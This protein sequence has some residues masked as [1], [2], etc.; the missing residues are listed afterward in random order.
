MIRA[1]AKTLARGLS[2]VGLLLALSSPAAA[3]APAGLYTS[4]GNDA[5][6]GTYR[7]RVELRATGP[8]AYDY[9]R[10]A[11]FATQ[12]NG[13]SLTV[14]W[15][16][17]A[18]TRGGEVHV[19]V[20]LRRVGWITR[21]GALQRTAA[22]AV[23]TSVTGVYRPDPAGGLAGVLRDATGAVS[24]T[25][26]ITYQGAP[27]AS[28]L[29]RED[30]TLG[31][32]HGPPPGWLKSVL[33]AVFNSF[34]VLPDIQPYVGRADFQAAVH[35]NVHDRSGLD[36]LRAHPNDLFV[37][38]Q[39]V[40]GITLHEAE[41]RR[42]A[43]GP[44]VF[45]KAAS[46]DQDA[47]G[48]H[49]DVG[50][51]LVY[52][53]NQGQPI[54]DMSSLLWSMCY[55][56]GQACRYQSTQDP[57]ALANVE[58]MAGVLCDLI[59]I[60]PRV[61]EFAR[62]LRPINRSPISGSWRAG[63]GRFAQLA[64][65][66]NGN[67]DMIKGVWLGFL[68]AWEVLPANSPLRPR[69]QDC[70]R[71]I[72]DHWATSNPSASGGTG[73]PRDK[74]GSTLMNNML[75]FWITGDAKYETAYK[76]VLRN[77]RV[78]LELASGGTFGAFGIADWSGTHLGVCTKIALIELAQ[79]LQS[80]WLPLFRLS[81]HNGW[82]MMQRYYRCTVMWSVAWAAYGNDA[83]ARDNVLWCMR[84]FPYPKP[85]AGDIDRTLDPEWSP[86]PYPSLPWK[87][88]WTTNSGR[89]SGLYSYPMFMRNTNNYYWRSG[90]MPYGGGGGTIEHHG[91]DF[92]FAYW[93]ARKH[94]VI[95]AGE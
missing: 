5:Q 35:Y 87:L 3:Q 13:R 26:A 50:G 57:Q 85:T 88:D 28:P 29:H 1:D 7:G 8:G 74:W 75:A 20:H 72:A 95:A 93:V 78:L 23:P 80:P 48:P 12:R 34:H 53:V 89:R 25:E 92:L 69:I 86:S 46:F 61:G 38:N 66:D 82:R 9:V 59:E 63:Q 40:D 90:P 11:T 41:L 58:H 91:A 73:H 14:V 18:V 39:I 79:H 52:G 15:T 71:E 83:T 21:L 55:A 49:R 32:L 43:Y 31:R 56:Y 51:L 68:G 84:E 54:E 30:R 16:G 19:Q 22:D 67:N 24:V 62:S 4:V 76:A 64:Y 36:W 47:E 37:V 2:A 17:R 42:S 45:E 27:G 10:E 6:L 77:P 65:H 81:L 44:R 33:F 94:G 60:D 70:M